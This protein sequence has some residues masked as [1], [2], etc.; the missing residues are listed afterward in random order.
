MT[1]RIAA[2]AAHPQAELLRAL[3][4]DA[5]DLLDA[6]ALGAEL[7]HRAVHERETV[8]AQERARAARAPRRF[9][10]VHAFEQ[11]IGDRAAIDAVAAQLAPV[12]IG[13]RAR[14]LAQRL[15]DLAVAH[16]RPA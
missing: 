15:D 12:V 8:R 13:E 11:V 1:E 6:V 14:V 16:R 5:Q 4:R 9:G 7:A 10:R 3:D 2:T